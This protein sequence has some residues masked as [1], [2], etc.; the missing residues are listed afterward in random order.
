MIAPGMKSTPLAVA[1]A[2]RPALRAPELCF[3]FAL[4]IAL[5]SFGCT[6]GQVECDCAD[7]AARVHIAED[8]AA[9]VTA[10]VL[11]GPACAGE[12]ATCEQKTSAGC[13]TYRFTARGAGGCDVDV[14]FAGGTFTAH[15][16]FARANGCCPG[17]Y[18]EPASSGEIEAFRPLGDAGG[19]E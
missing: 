1:F 11:R 7:P 9:A 4:G 13:A 3:P 18:A 10:I 19:A 6:Q 2:M 15:V 8:G 16:Q 5:V 17:Y 12:T 14:V